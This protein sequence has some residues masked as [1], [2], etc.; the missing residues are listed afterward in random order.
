M[1]F[2]NFVKM[3][4][5]WPTHP[6]IYKGVHIETLK[7]VSAAPQPVCASP[8]L[9]GTTMGICVDTRLVISKIILFGLTSSLSVTRFQTYALRKLKFSEF[10]RV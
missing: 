1:C 2:E 8:I 4:V 3:Q 9:G 5:G 6:C 10:P 7:A